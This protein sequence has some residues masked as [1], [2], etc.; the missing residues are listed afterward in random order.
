MLNK[1]NFPRHR[2]AASVV[3]M[4]PLNLERDVKHLEE[5]GVKNLHIDVMDGCAVPRYGIYPEIIR[6]I[7]DVTNM[8]MDVH[9]MVRD[10]LFALKQ[11]GEDIHSVNDMCFH[12]DHHVHDA[13]A[14][15]DEISAAGYNP[16]VVLNHA[17]DFAST[18]RLIRGHFIKYVLF[19]GI[20]PGVLQQVARP[21]HLAKSIADFKKDIPAG[22]SNMRIQV[23]GAVTFD[24][25]GLLVDAG[26]TDFVG[27]TGTIYHKDNPPS[28]NWEIIN[29]YLN[30]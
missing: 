30:L 9:L 25:L 21:R 6:R 20:H 7:A 10:P 23:D 19:M 11:I 5:L 27:G 29:S 15:A 18:Y 2:F 17:S 28:K 26:A 22:N 16:G 8:T 14:I 4:D 12:I 1:P 24:T 13:A 3:C